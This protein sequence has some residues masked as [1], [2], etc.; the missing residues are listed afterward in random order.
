MRF[1]SLGSGSQGNALVVE[2]AGTRILL[3]CGFSAQEAAL[4]LAR[5]GLEPADLDAV[6]VTHEHDDH[7]SGVA[8]LARRHGLPVH[9]TAGTLAALGERWLAEVAVTLI[10][11]YQP[12]AIGALEISPFPVPH[13]AGEPAQFVFSDGMRRLGMLTDTGCATPHIA[14]MLSGLDALVLECNHDT[15]LL[16]HGA[17]PAP[18]KRRIA[19]RFGHL[20]NGAAARLLASLDT[21]RLRH[22]IAAHLSRHNNTPQLARAA[23]AGALG[24][25]DGWIGVASQEEGFGWREI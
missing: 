7:A 19:G 6:V 16:A 5:I 15:E 4:R 11:E 3:D 8:Q 20:D 2:A 24:C 13:D 21:S 25:E 12:F 17:Y 10:P 23:L 22:V 18:L 1:A 9:L 14:A